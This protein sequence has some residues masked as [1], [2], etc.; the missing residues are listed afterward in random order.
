MNSTEQKAFKWLKQ[1]GA[2]DIVFQIRKNPDFLT[3]NLGGFEVKIALS[4]SVSFSKNQLN[5]MNDIMVHVT[6]L[7]YTK[8][9]EDPLVFT[10]EQLSEHYKI[11][12]PK[13]PRIQLT[14]PK[15]THRKILEN[16]VG[17]SP[18]RGNVQ[19][20]I[21]EALADFLAKHTP[22]TKEEKP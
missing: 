14:I 16:Y 11:L 17:T 20:V 10:Y 9:A 22:P 7:I 6:Y 21:L 12:F 18:I 13:H 15:I 5:S 8:T 19:A 1:H 3:S 2:K 4:R